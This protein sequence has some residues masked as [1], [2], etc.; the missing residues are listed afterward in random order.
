M[1]CNVC[2][3]VCIDADIN[4]PA[5]SSLHLKFPTMVIGHRQGE[6]EASQRNNTYYNRYTEYYII[7]YLLLYVYMY[8]IYV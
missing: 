6:V 7:Y 4:P 1:Y 8:I 5:A 3:Y 2:M